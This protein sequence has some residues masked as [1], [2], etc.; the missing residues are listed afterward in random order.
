MTLT[1]QGGEQT[2]N[3]PALSNTCNPHQSTPH[4]C[5]ASHIL[6]TSLGGAC[7]RSTLSFHL[8][9]RQAATAPHHAHTSR[10]LIP[11]PPYKQGQH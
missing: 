7:P 8:L 6:H 2:T 1:Q 5:P 10:R 3:D 9:G 11:R 4:S